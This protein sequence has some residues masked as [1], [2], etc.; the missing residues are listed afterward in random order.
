[1]LSKYNTRYKNNNTHYCIITIITKNNK[2]LAQG[3]Y[4]EKI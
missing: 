3:K 2:S 4:N 1:M